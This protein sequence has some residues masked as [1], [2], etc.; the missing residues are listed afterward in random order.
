MLFSYPRYFAD[1][2]I[3]LFLKDFYF[4]MYKNI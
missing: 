1:E 4:S 3:E 2:Y